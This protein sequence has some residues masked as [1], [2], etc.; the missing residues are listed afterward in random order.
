MPSPIAACDQRL[1]RIR[2]PDG[3]RWWKSAKNPPC[4]ERALPRSENVEETVHGAGIRLTTPGGPAFESPEPAE[5]QPRTLPNPP[6]QSENRAK[7]MRKTQKPYG[8]PS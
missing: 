4:K 7:T 8:K 3:G 5:N 6:N 1:R 2:L